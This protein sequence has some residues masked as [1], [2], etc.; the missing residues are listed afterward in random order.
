MNV[1]IMIVQSLL[2]AFV[3]EKL[4]G[5]IG[6]PVLETETGMQ[7]GEVV[8]A[9]LDIEG[10]LV[11]GFIIAEEKWFASKHAVRFT[12]LCSV[13]SDAVMVDN[14]HI[15]QQVSNIWMTD[16]SYYLRDLC[17]K[18]IFTDAGLCL[19]VLVDISFDRV[20]GEIKWY[21]LS[22]GII[23]D[24]LYGRMIMPLPPTQIIGKDNIIVPEAM[25]NL[26]HT[27]T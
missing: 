19:G 13:G 7:I 20:T 15:V 4:R 2:E 12:D 18:Q 14:Q 27:E 9:V 8:E 6:L 11:Y 22:D 16:R 21:E 25:A 3:M 23:T 10:A 1:D 26:L 24:L 5:I 17:N